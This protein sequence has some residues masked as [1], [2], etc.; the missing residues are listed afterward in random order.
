MTKTTTHPLSL[1][2]TTSMMA[3]SFSKV[4]CKEKM[5]LTPN[6]M[7][8]HHM[9]AHAETLPPPKKT[10]LNATP[11][12]FCAILYQLPATTLNPLEPQ[13]DAIH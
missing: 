11:N 10:N 9:T 6:H 13:T 3:A 5:L 2:I 1:E 12:K 8:L 4:D 7:Q